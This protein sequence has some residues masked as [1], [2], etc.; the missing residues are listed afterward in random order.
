MREFSQTTPNFAPSSATPVTSATISGFSSVEHVRAAGDEYCRICSE[1]IPGDFY[2]ING[3]IG[4]Y[5]CARQATE[6][7]P[8]RTT[9]A[10]ASGLRSGIICAVAGLVLCAV[11]SILTGWTIGCFALAVGVM[12]GKGITV[13]SNG[14]GGPRFQSAAMILTYASVSLA[15][16]PVI[17]FSTLQSKQPIGSLARLL[18]RLAVYAIGAPIASFLTE[19]LGTIVGL[20][21][22][23]VGLRAAR[24]ITRYR[25]LSVVGPYS[26]T[27]A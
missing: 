8:L 6:G 22:L 4:C 3:Q 1:L 15:S 20:V 19:P 24:Q 27:P 13:G 16:I 9:A 10:Y 18:E 21:V 5:V 26:E 14:L 11:A 25:S 2:L 17:L 12:V 23:V 7:P